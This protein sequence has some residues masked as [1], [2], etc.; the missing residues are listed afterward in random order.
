MDLLVT[1]AAQRPDLVPLLDDFNDWPAFMREDML[2]PLYYGDAVAAHPAHVLIAV[3]RDR[4]DRLAAKGYSVPFT[5]EADPDEALPPGG[6]DEVILMAARDR[7]AGRRGTI[8]S[9]LEISVR[10]DLRG[11]GLSGVMLAAMRRAAAAEGYAS[12][13]APVRPNA[14]HLHPGMPA[15]AYADLRRDDGLPVDPWLRVHVRAGGRITGVSSRA[16]TITGSL[17]DWRS[18]TG[19]PFDT[20]GP[21]EVPEAL[22]PVH[23]DT[24]QDLAVYCEPCVWVHH[25]LS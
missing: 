19:L 20:A 23:C 13:V 25:P 2:S 15:A 5:W 12:L 16:M 4:P 10:R 14:K 6:W 17:A 8:V 7:L 24:A 9:A 11:T 3:D 18:W 22:V 21:V 1:T